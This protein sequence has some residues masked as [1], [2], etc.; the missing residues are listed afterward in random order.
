MIDEFFKFFGIISLI[1]LLFKLKF[2]NIIKVMEKIEEIINGG[3]MG[4]STKYEENAENDVENKRKHL[5]SMI[6]QDKTSVSLGKTPW[7]V[8]R[9][10]LASNKKIETLYN[11]SNKNMLVMN[12]KKDVISQLVA[13]KDFQKFQ[14]EYK[15]NF[16]TSSSNISLPDMPVFEYSPVELI[17][18]SI[19]FRSKNYLP[20]LSTFCQFFNALDWQI[21]AK[22]SQKRELEKP[23]DLKENG[24]II[25]A[26]FSERGEDG[27]INKNEAPGAGAGGT[28]SS[29][30]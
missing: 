2:P 22:I 15:S 10:R 1:F 12:P 11:I 19:Y 9:L 5:I 18:A 17:L 6:T 30:V 20:Y 14:A 7:T 3:C 26:N 16:L 13:M 23:E 29:C 24:Y 4:D 21:A 25:N 28:C 8:D 27:E